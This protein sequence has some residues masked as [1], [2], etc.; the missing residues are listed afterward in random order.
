MPLIRF[1][2][3]ALPA[4][5]WKNGGGV[6][7]E[8]LCLPEGSGF[9]R[10]DWR[11]SIAH[12]ASSGPFSAFPGVDR[13]I[14]L[15]EG[16]GV[17]LRS[18]DGAIDHRLDTPLAPFAFP[19]EAS[20]HGELLGTDCH[21][22]NVMTRRAACSARVQV[23]RE[24]GALPAC[25]QGLLMAVGGGWRANEGGEVLQ[26]QADEGLWWHGS[27]RSWHLVPDSAQS[28]LLAVSIEAKTP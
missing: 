20:V 12:I 14:T 18:A 2:R 1:H 7:R 15:L 19:G 21:D 17:H 3:S 10:F 4:Q 5:P 24:P 16:G 25:A 8:V 27:D 28:A 23:L 13:V 6:T 22:F 11:V 9:E 26:L